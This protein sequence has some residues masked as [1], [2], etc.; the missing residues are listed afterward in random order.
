MVFR[1]FFIT[2]QRIDLK[3]FIIR[4]LIDCIWKCI[5][6]QFVYNDYMILVINRF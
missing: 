1:T 4:M 5:E 2:F 3:S 6:L